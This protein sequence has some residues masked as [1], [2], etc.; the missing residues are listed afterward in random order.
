MH[1]GKRN[2]SSADSPCKA[3]HLRTDRRRNRLAGQYSQIVS[4]QASGRSAKRLPAMRQ[5]C[6]TDAAPQGEKVLL[7]QVPPALVERAS[8]AHHAQNRMQEKLFAL[9]R[10]I[11]RASERKAKILRPEMLR[12]RPETGGVN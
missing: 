2:V 9:R 1:D 8:G 11:H 10:G 4:A 3:V 5:T 6:H 12:S 7:G